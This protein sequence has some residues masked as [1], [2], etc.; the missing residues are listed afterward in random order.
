VNAQHGG[1]SEGRTT[2]LARRGLRLDQIRSRHQKVHLIQKLA[3]AR[4]FGRN[5]ESGGSKADLFLSLLSQ[6]SG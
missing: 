5:L 2:G 1:N 6:I 3:L 4:S